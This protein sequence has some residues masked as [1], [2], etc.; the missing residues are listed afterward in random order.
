[1]PYP[2][3]VLTVPQVE[4]VIRLAETKAAKAAEGVVLNLQVPEW[5]QIIDLIDSL[6]L[7][8][9]KELMALMWLGQGRESA[10]VSR[11][12][13]LIQDASKELRSDIASRLASRPGLHICL[14]NALEVMRNSENVARVPCG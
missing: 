5:Q 8:A 14:R 7:D 6:P 1:M 2:M 3:S 10:E 4:E 11:W 9:K 13:E 12:M